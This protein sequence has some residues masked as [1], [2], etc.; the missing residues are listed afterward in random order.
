MMGHKN[1]NLRGY[2]V[3]AELKQDAKCE[4]IDLRF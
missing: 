1:L 2:E 4:A 3:E